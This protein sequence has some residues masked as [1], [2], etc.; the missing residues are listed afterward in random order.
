M[1]TKTTTIKNDDRAKI[2][3]KT[4]T[5]QYYGIKKNLMASLSTEIVGV[6]RKQHN[7]QTLTC[8]W[9]KGVLISHNISVYSY[10]TIRLCSKIL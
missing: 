4:V 10:T 6:G 3:I 7:F 9:C 5:F 8:Y 1:P 2:S